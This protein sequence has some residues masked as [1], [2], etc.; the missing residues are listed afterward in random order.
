MIHAICS[1]GLAGETA[2]VRGPFRPMLALEPQEIQV[3]ILK[4]FARHNHCRHDVD[5]ANGFITRS[6]RHEICKTI[7]ICDDAKTAPVRAIL[8]GT[9]GKEE[10]TAGN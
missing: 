6:P 8:D 5:M 9:R 1:S 7:D 10:E 2:K 3:G 4:R